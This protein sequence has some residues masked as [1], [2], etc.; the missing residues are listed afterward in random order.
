M[1][2]IDVAAGLVAVIFVGIALFMLVAMVRAWRSPNPPG[3]IGTIVKRSYARVQTRL[4]KEFDDLPELGKIRTLKA[5]A[6]HR[7]WAGL[8]LGMPA[9]AAMWA[10]FLPMGA[11]FTLVWARWMYKTIKEYDRCSNMVPSS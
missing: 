4:D 9:M 6:M 1:D 2:I 5:Q 10:L 11:I 3:A 8:L 7:F